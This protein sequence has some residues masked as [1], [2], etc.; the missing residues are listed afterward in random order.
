MNKDAVAKYV[1]TI[2]LDVLGTITIDHAAT[3]PGK[4]FDIAKLS[5]ILKG[6]VHYIPVGNGQQGHYVGFVYHRDDVWL[7]YDG[8]EVFMVS[9]AFAH[10]FAPFARVWMYE[11]LPWDPNNQLLLQNYFRIGPNTKR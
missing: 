8:D 2:S 3:T 11:Q 7:V 10:H 5:M 4:D 6:F 9:A 1:A